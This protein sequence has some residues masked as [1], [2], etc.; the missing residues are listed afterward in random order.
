MSDYRY[1]VWLTLTNGRRLP[2]GIL[3]ATDQL[4]PGAATAVFRYD[5]A[6][7]NCTDAFSLH[8]V[9][10]P[11]TDA[12]QITQ[13]PTS[14]FHALEDA[15]PEGWGFAMLLRRSGLD[16][17]RATKLAMLRHLGGDGLGALA[18]SEEEQPPPP[19]T[20]ETTIHLEAIA[21]AAHRLLNHEA[22]PDRE[23]ALLLKA[24]SSSGGAR[25]KAV[26]HDDGA[27]YIAK[28]PSPRDA[29]DAVPIEAATLELAARAGLEVPERQ[30]RQVGPWPVLLIR[31]FDVTAAGGRHHLLSARALLRTD[32]DTGYGYSHLA[33]AIRRHG[34]R[35]ER[36]I[37]QLLRQLLFNVALCN[38]DD[39]LRNFT[40]L[41]DPAGW[42]LSPAYDLTPARATAPAGME[43]VGYRYHHIRLLDDDGPIVATQLPQL[44]HTFGISQ[45]RLRR[46]RDEVVETARQWKGCMEG[47]GVAGE[48]IDRL[49]DDIEPRI[50]A[51]VG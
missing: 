23:L 13:R 43:S 1:R 26:V 39:H 18:F 17:A 36:D 44:A 20:S 40:F 31:R 46:I 9:E 16:P 32:S 42:R 6:F 34:Y 15:L 45:Q 14:L 41:H 22:V 8:P 29:M 12:A 24:G 49:R 5:T 35:P 2:V 47:F 28:F 3:A 50:E 7:L 48:Q 19:F 11:L 38:T 33:E 10:L 21:D 27:E 30:L 4:R 25:P 37:P 51:L